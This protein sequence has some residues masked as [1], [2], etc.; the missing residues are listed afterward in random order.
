[1]SS[2]VTMESGSGDVIGLTTTTI[3][4]ELLEDCHANPVPA[5][6]P[7]RFTTMSTIP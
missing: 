5:I 7:V 3:E 6:Y 1:M 4:L 2:L